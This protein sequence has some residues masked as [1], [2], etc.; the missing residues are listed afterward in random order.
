MAV[1]HR[2]ERELR[3][4]IDQGHSVEGYPSD[5]MQPLVFSV[6]W[7]LGMELLLKAGAKDP[8]AILVALDLGDAAATAMLLTSDCPLHLRHSIRGDFTTGDVSVLRYAMA[9]ETNEETVNLIVHRLVKDRR[10]ITAVAMQELSRKEQRVLG[11]DM[12][13]KA[14]LL[15]SNLEGVWQAL[16]RL[17][18]ILPSHLWPGCEPSATVY[19]M[20]VKWGGLPSDWFCH[21][22]LVTQAAESLYGNGFHDVDM[23]DSNGFN[24][25]YY[26]C[27][28]SFRGGKKWR[29]IRW[30]LDKG[31]RPRYSTRYGARNCLLIIS[32]RFCCW[33]HRNY[34]GVAQRISDLC[35]P[36]STDECFCYCSLNGCMTVTLIV[37][38]QHPFRNWL[39]SRDDIENWLRMTGVSSTTRELL[40]AGTCRVEVF[41]RLG[42]VHTCCKYLHPERDFCL[43]EPEER[44]E[45]QQEDFE[46][47]L[48]L[49]AYLQLYKDLRKEHSG[50]LSSFWD[51]W[52]EV[53]NEVLLPT[54]RP[55]FPGEMIEVFDESD[56]EEPDEESMQTD[57]SSWQPDRAFF[58]N[59]M[60]ARLR[61]KQTEDPAD[62]LSDYLYMFDETS[63]EST[64]QQA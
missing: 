41:H 20:I 64:V 32:Y 39:A 7:P 18:V 15:D 2:S 14:D 51:A 27:D 16:E 8:L 36:T 59:A 23:I 24:P 60:A 57:E 47:K 63:E 44:S 62:I 56:E 45:L 48:I 13:S 22:Q 35:D 19:H 17:N 46:F 55:Q 49:D 40:Y 11:L 12:L 33:G 9:C 6:G 29:Y 28:T 34:L 31:A 53:M 21:A 42:M 37:K 4:L 50:S 30:L 5:A 3:Q 52:W 61:W 54:A 1:I 25:L 58:F 26:A 38:S 43:N 10:H